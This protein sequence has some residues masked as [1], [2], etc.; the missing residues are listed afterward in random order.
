MNQ[1]PN[2]NQCLIQNQL[3]KVRQ[4]LRVTILLSI[5]SQHQKVNQFLN[6]NLFQTQN[7][8]LVPLTSASE[9]ALVEVSMSLITS[10]SRITI[11]I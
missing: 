2:H 7:Q 5:P 8:R 4:C 3:Q 6:H 9:T 1:F 10:V 11:S